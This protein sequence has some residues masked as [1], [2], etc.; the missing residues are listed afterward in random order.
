MKEKVIRAFRDAFGKDNSAVVKDNGAVVGFAPGRVNLIGE[1]TD[2]NGGHVFPCAI[3]LGTYGAARKRSD[4][5]I[6][7]CS[8]ND[9]E[10]HV[11]Q[12]DAGSNDTES[13]ISSD[14]ET[15][16]NCM[17]YNI[18][19]SSLDDL[20]PLEDDGWTSYVMGVIWAFQEHGKAA[21]GTSDVGKSAGDADTGKSAGDAECGKELIDYGLDILIGG[22]L[23]AGA[24]LSSSASLEVLIGNL[25][26]QLFGLD[27]SEQEIALLGQTA[28]N[29]YVGVNCGIMDQFASAMGKEDH[30]IFLD[31][32]TLEYEYVPLSLGDKKIVI[33]NTNKKH[34]LNDSAYNDRLRECS[35]ALADLNNSTDDM[36]ADFNGATNEAL[37]N[38]DGGENSELLDEAENKHTVN[39]TAS[40]IQALGDLTPDD[41][42]GVKSHINDEI[43]LR[44]ARHAV[45]EN[46]RTKDA[47]VAL[48]SGDLAAFGKLMNESH[49]SLRDDYEVTCPELDLLAESAWEIPGVIGSRMTGG[50]FGGCTVS[51]V[52]ADAV[53]EFC[54]VLGKKYR[55]AFGYDCTFIIA[56][57]GSGPVVEE[58]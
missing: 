57:A 36:L 17:H 16:A 43:C 35:E 9:P 1:H 18:I 51:I 41:F 55:E 14:R 10:T 6:R 3:T 23:P 34:S 19:E 56:S 4:R 49:V 52:E 12:N 58:L 38:L 30:A 37:A 42:D 48:K 2:Y 7:L 20:K 21:A 25:L 32:A 29:K 5:K 31:A 44:R 53:D 33:T 45:T 11:I 24:G 27:V 13:A 47:V 8:L 50:G 15:N 46:Q 54:E 28:E 40:K 22:D 26:K 39:V